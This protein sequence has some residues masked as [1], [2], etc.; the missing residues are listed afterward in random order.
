[1]H[2]FRALAGAL[3]SAALLAGSASAAFADGHG[4]KGGAGPLPMSATVQARVDQALHFKDLGEDQ[5][6][7]PFV[8]ELALQGVVQGE[9]GGVFAPQ[10]AVTHAQAIVMVDRVLAPAGGAVAAGKTLLQQSGYLQFTDANLIPSWAAP[11][12]A[13]AVSR[14]L[15]ANTGVLAPNASSTRAWSAALIVQ[16]LEVGGYLTSAQAAQYAATSAGFGDQSS[17][18]SADVGAVNIAVALG[19]VDGFPTGDFLPAAPVT[20][21]E[22]AKMLA[23]ADQLFGVHAG[24][25]AVGI[26]QAVNPATSS[27]TISTYGDMPSAGGSG[28][29]STN[30]YTVAPN[31][32]IFILATQ[33]QAQIGT[34][35][36]VGQGDH[37]RYV[38]DPQGQISWLWDNVATT[39]VTGTMVSIS[40]T[41]ISIDTAGNTQ[42]TYALAP[43][44][45]VTDHNRPISP[46]ALAQGQ[47]VTLSVHS[48]TVVDIRVGPAPEQPPPFTFPFGPGGN[49]GIQPKPNPHRHDH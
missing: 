19:I 34:L 43:G 3:L 23:V 14:G 8:A 33:G 35:N 36:Q 49:H 21:A 22:F 48:G 2:H 32:L 44:V 24:G 31:A 12:I 13:Y 17:I 25:E 7:A 1:M 30:S 6:A 29:V 37:V 26:V 41:Q 38:V 46:L 15:V 9:G 4:P 27:V 20:R 18:P 11:Y 47:P 28:T 16:A 39:Q 40:S 42:A 45:L 5:W 10:G